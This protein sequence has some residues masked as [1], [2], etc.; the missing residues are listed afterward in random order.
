MP[1]INMK[2]QTLV[3]EPMVH[4]YYQNILPLD[5]ILCSPSTVTVVKSKTQWIVHINA[6]IITVWKSLGITVLKD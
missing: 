6:Q 2:K 5:P 1:T 4:G 3:M